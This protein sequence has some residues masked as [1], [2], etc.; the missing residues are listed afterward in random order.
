M[1]VGMDEPRP[2]LDLEPHQLDLRYEHLRLLREGSQDRLVGSLSAQG[3]QAPIVVIE[4]E[5]GC[6]RVI[7]GFRRVRALSRLGVDTVWATVWELTDVE[8]LLLDRT[9]RSAS[10]TVLEQA[11]L[12]TELSERFGLDGQELAR[13]FD[14]SASWV[15]RRLALVQVLP[16]EV[17]D[18]VREGR[19]SGH[20][21]MR[22]LV[23]LARAKPASAVEVASASARQRL[24]SREVGELVGLLR[25]VTTRHRARI[26]ADPKLALKAGGAASP[27][28]DPGHWLTELESLAE[29]IGWLMRRVPSLG[30][31]GHERALS[32]VAE[33][34]RAL[35]A[36]EAQLGDVAC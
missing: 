14:R 9:L 10:E 33:S 24:T 29:R 18:W 25:R 15:S 16:R 5:G 3:Q 19:L 20:T 6:Y 8:A 12:L 2:G 1:L 23:P 36:A 27:G 11:W 34:V 35:Q 21:A 26:L 13:R 22:Y 17:Q 30:P 28:P 31:E 32:A 4:A 7:D